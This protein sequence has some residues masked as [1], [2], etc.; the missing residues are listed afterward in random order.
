MYVKKQNKTLSRKKNELLLLLLL[1]AG[2]E[3][4]NWYFKPLAAN[5]CVH[6]CVRD[7]PSCSAKKR[8]QHI[9]L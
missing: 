4:T 8:P 7:E 3:V 6:P 9:N 1:R 5:L 2:G